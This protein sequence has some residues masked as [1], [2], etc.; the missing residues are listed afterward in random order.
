M[1]PWMSNAWLGLQTT[2]ERN[3]LHVGWGRTS[4]APSLMRRRAECEVLTYMLL[5]ASTDGNY[6]VSYFL[7]LFE[8]FL[9]LRITACVQ[10]EK[11]ARAG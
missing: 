2:G 6:K 4:P 5:L 9:T 7:H 10:V 11:K 8:F 3:D 1:R